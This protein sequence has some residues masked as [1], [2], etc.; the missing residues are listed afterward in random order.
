MPVYKLNIEVEFI[1]F[2]LLIMYIISNNHVFAS[3]ISK[4]L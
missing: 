3:L 4:A 2:I 1:L